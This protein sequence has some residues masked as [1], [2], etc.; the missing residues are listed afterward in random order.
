MGEPILTDQ[1]SKTLDKIVTSIWPAIMHKAKR[2]KITSMLSL[3][4]GARGLKEAGKDEVMEAV[5]MV[6]PKSYDPF[7][8]MMEDMETFR[9]QTLDTNVDM[10]AYMGRHIEVR[11]WERADGGKPKKPADQMKITAFCASPRRKGNTAL[12]VEEALRGAESKG[13]KGEIVNLQK[14]NLKF[15]IGCRRCK[16]ADFKK[17]CSVKDDM[18]EIYRKI[19]DSDVIIVGFPVYSARECA[20]LSTFFDRWDCFARFQFQPKLSPGRRAMVIG[21]WG[22]P[23]IDTYDHVIEDV[24][25]YLNMHRVVPVEALSACGFEGLLHGLDE[26]R[27]GRIAQFPEELAK[28]YQAGIGLVS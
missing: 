3:M 2:G 27:K 6:V 8:H 14:I 19:I 16:E 10:D 1:G 5:R 12:I 7:F 4:L 13:A 11:R 21:T 15:C 17:M 24:M 22:Y 26:K 18:P 20:Q 23:H 9:R 28:A 25:L